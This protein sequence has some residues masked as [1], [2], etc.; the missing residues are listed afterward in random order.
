MIALP[1]SRH[2]EKSK[3]DTNTKEK[4][5]TNFVHL[6]DG[7]RHSIGITSEG[8]A[9]SWG[10]SN[11][12]GQLGRQTTTSSSSA[13]LP[14]RVQLPVK[15][16][17]A[18]TSEGCTADSGHSAILDENGMLWM[19]GCDRWQQLGLG[20]SKGGSSGYTW[21][22]GKLWQ[23]TFIE[24]I[25]VIDLMKEQDPSSTIR[26]V[27]LGGDHTLILSSNQR[28]V[29]AFGKGGDGQLGLVGKP[30]VSAPI[31]SKT[32][33]E[34]GVAALCAIKACSMTLDDGGRVKSKAGKCRSNVVEEGL[35]KC[36][37]RAQR[38]GLIQMS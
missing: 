24:S 8:Y 19:A 36:R 18:F 15:A 27:A 37:A 7:T 6:A 11:A 2:A 25:H 31:K 4:N 35:A 33:S 30:F 5:K 29:Y 38:N 26:D 13:K 10:R 3:E 14:G 12:L 16:S 23:E 28:D 1:F 22:D 17:K 21:K 34:S 32:L 20:S 9:I